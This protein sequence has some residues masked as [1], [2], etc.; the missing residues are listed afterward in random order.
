[1]TGGD[2]YHYT[3]EDDILIKIVFLFQSNSSLITSTSC[4]IVVFSFSDALAKLDETLTQPDQDTETG[5]TQTKVSFSQA[6]PEFLPEGI[7]CQL[8]SFCFIS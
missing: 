8:I 4:S 5:Q 7:D 2:T 3:N 6:D 1:M